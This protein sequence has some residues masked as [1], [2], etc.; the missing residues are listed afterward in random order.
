MGIMVE[1]WEFW[2]IMG[3]YGGF[4]GNCKELWGL[5]GDEV[6]KHVQHKVA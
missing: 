4:L 3:I 2:G 1:I 6:L 5:M